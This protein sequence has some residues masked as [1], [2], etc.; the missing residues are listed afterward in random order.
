[1]TYL[2]C[3][4][5]LLLL[6]GWAT[7]EP[8]TGQ[9]RRRVPPP[10]TPPAPTKPTPIRGLVE[11]TQRGVLTL[12]RFSNGLR[13]ICGERYSTELVSVSAQLGFGEI[14]E[15]ESASGIAWVVA[16]GL[17]SEADESE[18]ASIGATVETAV[19]AQRVTLAIT[20][21]A[22]HLTTVVGLL[23]RALS[24]PDFSEHQLQRGQTQAARNHLVSRLHTGHLSRLAWSVL[25]A[26]HQP[27]VPNTDVHFKAVNL[28]TARAFRLAHLS[29]R[30]VVLAVTGNLNLSEVLRVVAEGNSGWKSESA[31]V[32][33]QRL[34]GRQYHA[35]RSPQ[36]RTW[37][38]LGY[39]LPAV[40]NEERRA[41]DIIRAAL[42][43]GARSRLQDALVEK[44]QIASDVRTY[45]EATPQGT[46]FCFGLNVQPERLDRAEALVIEAIERF[47]RERLS[48]GELQRARAQLEL[49]RALE[50]D[51]LAAWAHQLISAE[52][53]CGLLTW[54][55]DLDRLGDCDAEQVRA[56]AA[57]Y[58]VASQLVVHE[59]EASTAPLRTFTPEKFFETV[60]LLVPGTLASDIPASEITDAQETV[61]VPTK[62][63]PKAKESGLF[64]LPP[65]EPVR[66][67]ATLRGPRVLV[68]PDPSNSLVAIGLYFQ[69]GRFIEDEQTAGITEL[70]LRVIMRYTVKQATA[71]LLD[72]LERLGG[73]LQIVNERDFFG[74]ELYVL[75]RHAEEALRRLVALVE[76]PSFEAA[77]VKAERERLL[78]EQRM[79]AARPIE[80]A[81]WLARKSLLPSHPYG[82][83]ALG[84]NSTVRNL[85]E[86]AVQRWYATTIQRQLP[87]IVIVGGTQG[88]ALVT[89][90]ITEGFTRR[91]TDTSLKARVARPAVSPIVQDI[92]SGARDILACALATPGGRESDHRWSVLATW[93]ENHLNANRGDGETF[94]VKFTP[95]LQLGEVLI[96]GESEPEGMS[97][98]TERIAR[99]LRDLA[100]QPPPADA[101]R[102]AMQETMTRIAQVTDTV[103]GRTRAYATAVYLGI[104]A[105]EVDTS[106]ASIRQLPPL[107]AESW[108][109]FTL[110]TAGRGMVRGAPLARP[111]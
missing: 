61:I 82:F 52:S 89:R 12:V 56:V 110:E 8:A 21:S 48:K 46:T 99:T 55:D 62:K 44:R 65:A 75:A 47:R 107:P 19:E 87:I 7:G 90:D 83:P 64:S 16:Y 4:W 11:Q 91:E 70:M 78:A 95:A 13:L 74:F 59:Y 2:R 18:L 104:A 32:T 14:N 27:S 38:H 1:M 31:A 100:R 23:V 37:V 58:L 60:G 106:P 20:A 41:L 88:S 22:K 69:G 73:C 34:T 45:L 42:S 68:R 35:D 36:N 67:Y 84:V 15:P 33:P 43:L 51:C 39:V 9:T 72:E 109:G 101:W 25:A 3:V 81:V 6:I 80:L 17:L 49:E 10:L 79:Q 105:S 66:E 103:R 40:P 30:K 54:L 5:L 94:Q 96:I 102:Q 63:T 92:T 71:H 57:K 50:G 29:P 93:L 77:N 111:K 26:G 85:D 24:R 28:E 76:R 98:L 86:S 97:R 108:E 53:T